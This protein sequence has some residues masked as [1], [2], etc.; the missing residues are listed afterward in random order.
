MGRKQVLR[1]R[2]ERQKLK[3][4]VRDEVLA[5]IASRDLIRYAIEKDWD[6]WAIALNNVYGFGKVRIN[7]LY[8]ELDAL[9]SEYAEKGEVDWEYADAVRDRRTNQIMGRGKDA[10]Q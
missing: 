7:R 8:D 2:V 6:M 5:Q 1:S 3:E 10:A 4:E 9:Y